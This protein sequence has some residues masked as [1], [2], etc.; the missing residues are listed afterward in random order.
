[1]YKRIL[2]PVDLGHGTVAAHI[3]KVAR[4]LAGETGR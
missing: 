2:V 1:M 4:W 3:L